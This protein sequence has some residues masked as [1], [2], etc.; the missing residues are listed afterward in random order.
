MFAT[1]RAVAA[2]AGVFAS[3][4]SDMWRDVFAEDPRLEHV[5]SLR[6]G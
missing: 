4:D 3:F 2:Y 6:I 5:A 1:V